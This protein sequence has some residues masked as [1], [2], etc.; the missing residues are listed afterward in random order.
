MSA[1]A[2]HRSK[3][4]AAWW[5][6]E[7]F[8]APLDLGLAG[9]LADFDAAFTL[10]HD[11]YVGRGYMPRGPSGRRLSLHNILPST[12][13]IV[14]KA[15]ARVVGTLTVVEDSRLGLPM[16]EAFGMEIGRLR[17]RRRRVVEAGSLALDPSSRAESPTVLIRLFRMAT[18]YAAMIVRADDLCF[19]VH[20]RHRAFYQTLFPFQQFPKNRVYQ[21]ITAWYRAGCQTISRA[22]SGPR[23]TGSWIR[24]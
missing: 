22:V 21:R 23:A 20:P 8:I 24:C 9:T 3:L 4:K 5:A 13:V 17:Q 7:A 16:D 19:V 10:L 6:E 2:K 12:K 15:A 18:L 14:A 1:G 11:Q